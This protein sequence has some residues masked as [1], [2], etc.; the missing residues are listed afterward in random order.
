M[1][2][3]TIMLLGIIIPAGIYAIQSNS[4][5]IKS[6]NE[7]IA[8]AYL[9]NAPTFKFD[10][11]LSSIKIVES[12]QAQTFA[13]PSFWGVTIEFDCSHAGYGDR[14]GQIVA[15]VIAHHSISMHVTEGRV[16][17]AIMDNVWNE[18]T[19]TMIN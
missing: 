14:S 6:N 9:K 2:L 18:I 8:L 7:A 15:Q 19:Q 11:I 10:G 1:I 12:F 4:N 16:S 5:D 17:L 3:A 13:Y